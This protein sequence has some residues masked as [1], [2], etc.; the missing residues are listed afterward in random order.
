[1][2]GVPSVPR[3][4]WAMGQAPMPLTRELPPASAFPH[5]ALG[6]IGSSVVTLMHRV[7]QAP[8]ALVGQT[9]LAAMN[10]ASQPYANVCI[11]GRVSPLSEYFLTLGE[12]G[13]RKSAA[14]GWHWPVCASSKNN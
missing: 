7:I 13:E 4:E 3:P 14:D 9:I 1:M 2:K 8:V 6:T 11:D 5:E 12:S 10:Q